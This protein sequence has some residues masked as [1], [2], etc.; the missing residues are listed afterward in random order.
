MRTPKKNYH[1]C[2]KKCRYHAGG[3]WASENGD[4]RFL[5]ITGHTKLG[6]MTEEQRR[7]YFA[8]EIRCPCYSEGP[9]PARV[10]Q[11]NNTLFAS[12]SVVKHRKS[13]AAVERLYRMGMNDYEIGRALDI[14]ASSVQWWRK[15]EGLP[16]NCGAGAPMKRKDEKNAD[17]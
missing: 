5:D 9:K 14:A 17:T 10:R 2:L 8:R 16:A 12:Q 4:C 15:S 7:L 13:W 11:R 6:R 3:A 1:C